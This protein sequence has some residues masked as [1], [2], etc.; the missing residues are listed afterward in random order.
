MPVEPAD[1]ATL[2]ALARVHLQKTL[3]NAQ[4][5]SVLDEEK[6]FTAEELSGKMVE[7]DE[8]LLEG[9][10]NDDKLKMFVGKRA[11]ANL[12]C[13]GCHNIPG[14]ESSKTIGVGLNDWGK[15]DPDRIAFEDAPAFVHDHFNVVDVRRDLTEEEKKAGATGWSF[16]DGKRPYE[17]FYAERLDHRHH[18][19]EGFLHLKLEEPRSYDYNR[20]RSWDDRLRMPQFKYARV[21]Q[22]PGESNEDFQLRW[23]KEEAEAREAVMTFVLGSSPI[24][25]RP[26]SCTTRPATSRPRSRAARSSRNSIAPAAT[27]CGPARSTSS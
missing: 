1:H 3:T 16:K 10:L 23:E 4:L 11:I 21:K 22:N 9:A 13:F 7:A 12:G 24:R 27:S 15:K 25:S 6:G 19:R 20:I 26:S 2:K 5:R 18:T 14:F 8:R 17:R